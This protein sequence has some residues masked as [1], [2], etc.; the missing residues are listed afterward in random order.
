MP[1]FDFASIDESHP[2]IVQ[3][4]WGYD[5]VN[6]NVPEGSYSTDAFRGEVRI[7]EMKEM[8][9]ALHKAGI[10]VIMDVVYNHMFDAKQSC[11]EKAEPD[12][13]FRKK[14][15]QYSDASACGNEV[16]SEH[17]M[18]R[19]YIVDSVCY[20]AKEY[21]MDGFRFDLMGVLDTETMQELGLRLKEINPSIVLY[22]EGWMGGE[23]VLP[24]YRRAMKKNERMFENVGMFSDDIRDN[25]RGHVFYE[26]ACGFVNGGQ[27][28]ENAIRYSVAG[29]V[30]HP[31]VDYASYSYT[32]GGPWAAKPEDTIS[33]VSCHDNLT[34]WDKLAVSRPDCSVEERYAMNRLAAAIVFTSQGVP[35]FLSGEEFARTKPIPGTNKV[36]E[37]SYN[38]TLETNGIRYDWTKEQEDLQEYY[39]GL[40]AFRKAHEGLRLSTAKQIR[41]DIRFVENLP[42]NVV[43]FTV[44][45]EKETLF[46]VYNANQKAV[47]I[48]LPE[49]EKWK[50]YVD[51]EH[52]GN[53]C[54]GNVSHTAAV[55]PLSCMVC[56]TN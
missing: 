6:Y 24:E 9:A 47:K 52:A 5:P 19:R 27:N 45:T 41:E 4:N 18:V 46:V 12:Y 51:A 14:N 3:Y 15:G 20:W 8:V 48:K 10:G 1:A 42:A 36:S 30:W 37:N 26:E 33:Y 55:R 53:T 44:R 31:Q 43:A 34:L 54:I 16:A 28:L 35:F 23:S 22:G 7:R 11:F 25:V 50:V 21:H 49:M 2:E 40:I 32:Q 56:S 39:K 29:A 38:L 17:P 13:F